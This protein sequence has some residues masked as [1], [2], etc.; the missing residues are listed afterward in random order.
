MTELAEF[1][2]RVIQ[3][4]D[5]AEIPYMVV[6]SVASS[7]HGNPRSTH[8]IDIVFSPTQH[9]LIAVVEKFQKG[10]YADLQSA[11]QA[12][13]DKSMFNIVDFSKGLKADL[14]FLKDRG[15]DQAEFS[16]RQKVEVFGHQAWAASAEDVILSKLEW[17]KLGDSE[18]QY[19]DATAVAAMQRETLDLNYLR[20]WA[21]QLKV[22]SLLNRLLT[23]I[24]DVPKIIPPHE[25]AD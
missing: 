24:A 10:L 6:G 17:S 23:E 15:F 12:M 8:D 4:L 2:R 20:H 5:A 21:V 9:Q 13:A 14:I 11:Q 19:R 1:L 7:A 25:T 18:R 16:R 22:E 3:E